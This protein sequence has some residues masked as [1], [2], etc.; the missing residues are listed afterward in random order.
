MDKLLKDSPVHLLAS[1]LNRLKKTAALVVLFTLPLLAAAQTPYTYVAEGFDG[2]QMPASSGA[3]PA[4]LTWYTTSTGTWGLFKGYTTTSSDPCPNGNGNRA[5]RFPSNAAAYVITPYLAQGA[6][7]VTFADGRTNRTITYWTSTDDGVTWSAPLTVN[8]GAS[9]CIGATININ[10]LAVNRMKFANMGTNDAGMDNILITPAGINK[11]VVSTTTATGITVITASSGGT[12]SSD[13]GATVSDRGLVWGTSPGPTTAVNNG[14]THDGTGTGTYASLLNG[15]AGGTTYYY[16]AFAINSAGTSYG[17]E[18]SFTTPPATPTLIANPSSLAFGMQTVNTTSSVM[19]Y[20][21]QG[22]YLNPTAGNITITAP[23]GYSISTSLSTPFGPTATIPYTGATLAATTIYVR[24]TPTAIGAA[25]GSVANTGGGAPPAAVAVTGAGAAKLDG[26]TN[27]GFDFW[28]GFGYQ[29]KMSQ[30]AGNSN[31]CKLSVYISVPSGATSASVVV[32]MPGIAGAP[33]FPRIVT[34]APG[35]VQ[36]ITGFPTGDAADEM[37]PSG[38]PDTRLYYT[39][40]S[41][42][43]IH[44]YSANG[45]P[46]AVWMHSYTTGNSAA[47]AMLFPS[48]T[49]ASSYTV[50]AYG[51]YSNTSNP[52]S[53]FFVVAKED[54]TPIWFTPSQ[55]V[56]DSSDNTIFKSGHT[57]A[58]VQYHKNVEYGPIYLNKGEIFNAMGFITGSGTGVGTGK[59]FGLDLSGS[60]VRTTCDK[61]IAV[62][63]G[64]GRCLVLPGTCTA[65]TGSDHMIQQMF[66]SVAW[67]KRYLT[68]PTRTMEYNLYRINVNDPSTRVWVNN[69]GHTTV[70]TGLIDNLYYQF[71]S[72]QPQLIE[73]DKPITVS[74]FIVAG[75]CATAAGAKGSGDPEFIT[76]SPVEQAISRTT[77]WSSRIKNTNST[78]TNGHYINVVIPQGGVASFRLDGATTGDPGVNQATVGAGSS[79]AYGAGTIQPL[80][81]IFQPHPQLAGFAY[82]TFRVT[83]GAAHTLTSDS[84]FNAIAYGMGDGESYGYNAGATVKDLSQQV[85]LGNPYG[86]TKGLTCKDNDFFFRVALPYAPADL[87]SLTWDF[88]NEPTLTPNANVVQNLPTPDSTYSVDGVPYYVYR[89]PTTYKFSQAGTYS[90][91]VLANAL[92]SGGCTGEKVYNNTVTVVNGPVPYFNF[93]AGSCGSTAITFTDASTSD[94]TIVNYWTWNF[95]DGATLADTS[96]LQNPSYTYPGLNPFTVTLT[97]VNAAG[98]VNDTTR[99]VDLSGTL[100][101]SYTINTANTICAGTSVT[102]T[103]ASS[104]AGSYGV[105]TEWTWDFGDGSPVVVSNNGN[106]QTH[107]YSSIGA[108]TATLKVKTSLGCISTLFTQVITVKSVPSVTSSATGTICTGNALSY[109]ITSAVAGT[110]FNWSRAAVTGI[111]NAAVSNQ[112]SNPI[113][114]TLVNTT[115]APINVVY[116]ITPSANGCDGAVFT[117]TVTVYPGTTI[118]SAATNTICNNTAQAY[119]ITS[120]V[121]GATFSWSRPA[122]TGISNAAVSNQA[123]STITETL[124]N[125]T[126]APVDAVY[127]ITPSANGCAGTPFTYTVTV[128]PTATV[129][130]AATDAVCSGAPFTYTI[131]SGVTGTTYSWSRP[132]VA[133]I[134]NAAASGQTTNPISETLTNTSNAPVS[135]IYT[136]TPSANGCPGTPFTLTVTVNP[137]PAV[138]SNATASICGSNAQNYLITSDVAG[139]TYSWDRAAVAGISNTAASG[140]TANPITETLFNTTTSPINVVYSITPSFAGCAGT[141]FTYT[142]TVNPTPVVTS[143]ATGGVCSGQPL[144]YNITTTVAGSNFTWSRPAVTGISNAAVT[145]STVNPIAETLVNTTTNVVNVTYQVVTSFSGCTSQPFNYVV[146][147]TPTPTVTSA[148][149]ASVCSGAAFNYNI[150]S[151]VTGA[152]FSWSRAAVAGI[153]NAAATGQTSNPINETLTNTT[154]APVNVVYS[155]TPSANGCTGSPFTLT[156]TVNPH[157]LVTS[158]GSAQIC[159]NTAQNYTI[160]GTVAGATYTWDRGAF[161]GIT[162]PAVTGS[163]ANPITETLVNTTSAAVNVFYTIT[164]SFAGCTGTAVTYTVTVYPTTTVTSPATTTICN[165]TAQSY[166]MT[167]AVAGTSFDWSR[168][169]VTGISNP[170]ANGSG[171]LTIIEA[172]NNTT[173]APITVVYAITPIANGCPGTPFNYSVTVNPTPSV[174]SAASGSVCGGS[175]LAYTITSA[176][177][178]ATFSWDRAA[179]AGISNAAVSGQTTSSITETLVNTT[180]NPI[181]VDYIITPSANSCAG[182]AFTYTVTVNPTPSITSVATGGVCSG[183]PLSY[184]I[185]STVAAATYTWSRAAVTGI[186]NPAVSGQTT[187]PIAETL[188]NST[189]NTLSVVY[190][191]VAGIGGCNSAPFTY[192]VTVTPAPTVTSAASANIC[193]NTPHNYT[194][195]STV[196]GTAFNWSRPAVAGISNAA[197]SGQT[198]ATISETLINTSNAPVVVNYVINTSANGCPGAVFNYAVTVNPTATVTSAATGTVCSGTAQNYSITSSVG[199]ATFSWSRPAVTGISNAAVTNQAGS[200]IAETLVNTTMAPITVV[201]AITPS[202]AS[203]NGTPFTYSVTVNPKPAMTSAATATICSATLFTYTMTSGVAG[204]TYSW[205]RPAVTGISNPAVFGS[206]ANPISETLLNTGNTSVA[207]PYSI[208]PSANGCAGTPFTLTVTVNPVPV[209]TSAA[210][211]SVCSD[212]PVNYVITSS[213][214][215]STVQWSRAAV[216]GISNAAVSGQLSSIINEALVNTTNAPIVVAYTITPASSACGGV[217]F[218]LDVTVDPAPQV[219]FTVAQSSQCVSGPVTFTPLPSVPP[220]ASYIWNFGDNSPTSNATAPVHTYSNGGQFSASLTA[221][222][223]AGCRGTSVPHLVNLLPLLPAPR[224]SVSATPSSLLFTWDS[225]PGATSYE[226]SVD[227]GA[228]FGAPAGPTNFSHFIDGLAPLQTIAIIVRVNGAVVCQQNSSLFSGTVPLPDVGIFVPNTIS[229]N[230]DGRNDKLRVLGNNIARVELKVFNQWGQLLFAYS[231]NDPSIGWDGTLNGTMQPVGVYAYAVEVKLTDGRTVTKKGL[232]NLIR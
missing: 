100:T 30:K 200:L 169:A 15:L 145:N 16:R 106:P 188:T 42:R 143:A 90:F 31:E 196:T 227:G 214:A 60:A 221:T 78:T 27:V 35:T 53:F 43:G 141:P 168:P 210:T 126:N 50:Q 174:T 184:P 172:L 20:S 14:I 137:R 56:V 5:I 231:G 94:S 170:A 105:I 228:T 44:I 194:I 40:K 103:D 62:F 119:T 39:G 7:V 147:V 198:S 33:G 197:V 117:Y 154:N 37:N 111:S 71:A 202:F 129:T 183:Q 75:D 116:S 28:T 215:G 52:A 136:I 70:L 130:S 190:T 46:I 189:T 120:A 160:T 167:S 1:L 91:K 139:A 131:T 179:V 102:F 124:V 67:G 187:N 155:I 206:N 69:P 10:N 92:T 108:W 49:W 88:N 8:T 118:T 48:N 12:V 47:G 104:A 98:C 41:R 159:N 222:T 89:I 212:V 107:I 84:A 173:S 185:T 82:A 9:T 115:S 146:T 158:A 175:P 2:G 142:V 45:V 110:T 161:T 81:N 181:N 127:T 57:A 216:A 114:E 122:V 148:A 125:T 157:A 93:S 152:T 3:A 123:G 96:H 153:S 204:T 112:S 150:T 144:T 213:V 217:P 195:T 55:D 22:V 26:V 25:N 77:V 171:A 180:N 36:E 101:A 225:I 203:C 73:S 226:V 230:N 59:A 83:P 205:N 29:E 135:V 211:K 80:A 138:T 192:T 162:N 149:T 63:G 72:N 11:P 224:I 97:A 178:G 87:A 182:P 66:P 68:V 13:G 54:N 64:N 79:A 218:T 201:Y 128:N 133:G 86:V 61:S 166:T 229:P 219:D 19:S 191:I 121:S 223:A 99:I 132:A 165:N 74:Q 34:V 38:Q 17:A 208:T 21:L 6:A 140:Q 209:I 177:A 193:N 176:V 199:S 232:F 23:A 51:G 151:A 156:V 113:T 4:T 163:T 109:N 186:A 85:L 24:F 32:E 18:L 76:L 220:I 58:M 164:P 65:N 134:S 207:I 95:G